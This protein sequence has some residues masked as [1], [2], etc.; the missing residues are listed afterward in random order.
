MVIVSLPNIASFGVIR[1]LLRDE[2]NYTDSGVLDRTHLRF[3]T[4]KTAIAMAEGA[5]FSVRSVRHSLPT[6]MG[7]QRKVL[8]RLGLSRFNGRQVILV[9][10]RP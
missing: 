6:R 9:L 2:F 1:Q 3:F 7:W 8:E 5:G 4:R 10:R